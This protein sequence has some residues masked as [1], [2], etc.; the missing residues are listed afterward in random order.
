[1]NIERLDVS[2]YTIPT[3]EPESD[4][5]LTWDATMVVAAEV[6]AGGRTGLGF[7]YGS[8][9]CGT[10]IREKLEYFHDHH[11]VDRILF[12]GVLDRAGRVLRPDSDR[13]GTGLE[14]KRSDAEQYRED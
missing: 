12:D 6:T 7:T 13:P 3:E 10:V 5:T 9:A 8:R 14:L 2:A 11:R 4:G 1:V